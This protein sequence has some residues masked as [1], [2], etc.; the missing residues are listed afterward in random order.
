MLIDLDQWEHNI[1]GVFCLCDIVRLGQVH[2]DINQKGWHKHIE[3]E[4]H[5]RQFAD[6]FKCNFWNENVR[7][8]IKISLKYVSKG[9]I[10]NILTLVQIMA[11]RRPGDRPLSEPMVVSL[12]THICVTRPQWVKTL[13]SWLKHHGSINWQL[14]T[15]THTSRVWAT[16][17]AYCSNHFFF[18]K[19][20]EN[21]Q[22]SC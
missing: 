10:N 20:E 9:P 8:S 2:T 22:Q 6:T 7:I 19:S 17:S 11:W 5:V 15:H 14:Q 3:A 18:G 1:Q 12:L 16:M 21:Y 13:T 4:T